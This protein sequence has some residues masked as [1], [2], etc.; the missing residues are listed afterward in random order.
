MTATTVTSNRTRAATGGTPALVVVAHGSRDPRA[1]STVRALLDRV[2][3]LRPGLP[4]HL[5]HIELNAPLLPDTLA[6]LGD[7]EAVLVPLLLSRGHHVGRDFRAPR[8]G[9]GARAPTA[10][11]HRRAAVAS[12][13]TAPAASRPSARRR[14]RGSHRPRWAPTRRWPTCSCAAT[15]RPGRRAALLNAWRWPPPSGA[16]NR[17]TSHGRPVVARLQNPADEQAPDCHTFPLLFMTWK[18]PHPPPRTTPHQWPA[19]PPNP[20]TPRPHRLPARPRPHPALLRAAPPR[21]E[22]T[23]RRAG[24]RAAPSGTPAPAPASR[25]PWSAPRSAGSWAPPSAATRTSWRRPA[26]RTTSATR[27]SAIQRRTGAQRLRRGLRRLRGQRPVPP[28]A[29]PHRAQRVH[30]GRLRRAQP[31][32]RH[33]RRRDQ[34]PVAAR[35]PP[36]HG[37]RPSSGVRRRPPRLRMAPQGR[38]RRPHLL[39]GPGHGLGR[40]RGVLRARRRGRPGLLVT[41]TRTACSPTPSARSS[42]PPSAA[43]S[44]PAPTTPNSPPP[45]TGSS[46]RTGGRTATTAPRSPRRG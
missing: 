4:V 25:T 3:A 6:A 1:L 20:Q 38:P 33:A 35:R 30:R 11:G 29:H 44:R 45:S 42:R 13:F 32:P 28:P 37:P 5:G 36:A 26:S 43:T 14:P 10:R 40:R 46:P 34:V 24:G 39:R 2:R 22:D 41:S 21:R 9:G 31:H 27:P 12:C 15:K 16:G 8:P 23:G 19:T 17:A 18:A 7:G